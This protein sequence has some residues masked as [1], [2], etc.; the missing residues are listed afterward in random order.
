MAEAKKA[1]PPDRNLRR[2]RLNLP[3]GACDCHFHIYGPQAR[4]PLKPGRG[5]E[6]EDSTLDDLL[7]L[8]KVLGISR[9]VMV[10]SFQHG[11]S[12]E[13]ML[14]ALTVDRARFRGITVPAPDITDG[15]LEILDEA[16]V[17]G[18]RIVPRMARDFDTRIIDRVHELG[19]HCQYFV[20]GTDEIAAWRERILKSPGNFVLDNLGN[21]PT[22]KGID[23]GEFRFVLEALDT[24]RG[25]VKAIPRFSRQETLPFADTFPFFEEVARRY[26]DRMLWGTDWPHPNY[27]KPM[28]NDADLVDL[29][30]EW[31]K[32]E[33]LLNRIFVEN[34]AR[35]FGFPRP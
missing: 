28:P 6:F 10:Q 11:N 32:D 17:V 14:H 29:V 19:W 3:P 35:L 9:G 34:P 33:T 23:S 13:W 30:K 8:H 27:Y 25:W 31:A 24:G 16:G 5:V 26:P 7:A 21:P 12:Y 18:I 4:F 2:P 15:E 1:P 20:E 22:E